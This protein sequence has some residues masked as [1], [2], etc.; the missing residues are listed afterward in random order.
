MGATKYPKR[1]WGTE[2]KDKSI[3]GLLKQLTPSSSSVS[4]TDVVAV[5]AACPYI[6]GL[7]PVAERDA[8][9]VESIASDFVNE[10]GEEEEVE[11]ELDYASLEGSFLHLAYNSN[12]PA[13]FETPLGRA[14]LDFKWEAYGKRVLLT[15]ATVFSLQLASVVFQVCTA[16]NRQLYS[17]AEATF[18]L[19]PSP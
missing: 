16:H 10:D 11:E 6:L 8:D 18:H 3:L 19:P 1:I 12:E 14:I 13:L 5:H 2:K 9:E 7:L 17:Q 4:L 15:Q